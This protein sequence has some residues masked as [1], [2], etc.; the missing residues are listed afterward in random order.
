MFVVT[1]S[2]G[3][4]ICHQSYVVEETDGWDRLQTS[5]HHRP[6]D[7]IEG[8]MKRKFRIFPQSKDKK[9]PR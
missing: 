4:D 5:T 3:V 6:E 2:V 7:R 9:R 1:M 8:V